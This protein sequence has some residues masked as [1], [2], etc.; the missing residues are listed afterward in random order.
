MKLIPIVPT[1][2]V[3]YHESSIIEYRVSIYVESG[4]TSSIS[5]SQSECRGARTVSVKCLL[6]RRLGAASGV[7]AIV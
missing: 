6:Y 3:P 7:A 5:S 4:H 2:S 1:D